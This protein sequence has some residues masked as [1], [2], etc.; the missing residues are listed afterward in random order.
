MLDMDLQPN[1][2]TDRC[3]FG[4]ILMECATSSLPSGP[5]TGDLKTM[6]PL[7]ANWYS[8]GTRSVIAVHDEVHR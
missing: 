7:K 1:A 3:G 8:R 5:V 2:R 4:L 6:L